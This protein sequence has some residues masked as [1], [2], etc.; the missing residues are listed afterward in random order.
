M[1]N[2]EIIPIREI[3]R[4]DDEMLALITAGDAPDPSISKPCL[5]NTCIKN[6]GNCG[7]NDCEINHKDC[8][9]NVCKSN[10]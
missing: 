3:E 1:K 9:V 8:E 5:P 7:N 4:F 6:T 2:F 10:G